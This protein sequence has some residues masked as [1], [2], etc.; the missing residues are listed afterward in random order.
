MQ[1]VINSDVA[2]DVHRV[3]RRGPATGTVPAYTNRPASARAIR[4]DPPASASASARHYRNQLRLD[5]IIPRYRDPGKHRGQFADLVVD[6]HDRDVRCH[7]ANATEALPFRQPIKKPAMICLWRSTDAG[8]PYI[9]MPK[10]FVNDTSGATWRAYR[11]PSPALHAATCLATT[12]RIAPCDA[13]SR[14]KRRGCDGHADTHGRLLDTRKTHV[15]ERSS[16]PRPHAATFCN[17]K[18][19]QCRCGAAVT[20]PVW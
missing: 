18:Q 2:L 4:L 5:H 15:P 8:A 7:Q 1:P 11:E 19:M 9:T 13:V 6:I 17:T 12:A 16:L 14:S 10:R 20:V 3:L